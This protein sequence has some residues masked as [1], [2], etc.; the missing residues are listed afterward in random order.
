MEP[1]SPRSE[2]RVTRERILDAAMSAFAAEGLRGARVDEIA[3]AAGVNKRMLYHH[4]GDKSGLFRTVLQERV[5]ALLANSADWGD[6]A[7]LADLP[8]AAWRLLAW[9]AGSSGKW[10]MAPA[11][12]SVAARQRAG[13]V[14]DDV[15]AEFLAL[16]LVGAVVAPAL[17][18]PTV[19]IA[20]RERLASELS[21]LFA[22]P[23]A[24]SPRPRVRVQPTV[25]PQGA[26]R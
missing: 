7:G 6:P 19:Q 16:C 15:S 3:A 23:A 20:D 5:L 17:L 1:Q 24:A 25:Q 22:A 2:S 18:D 10:S 12:A 13:E 9:D 26:R 4:F 14:R 11:V 21:Q 8:P